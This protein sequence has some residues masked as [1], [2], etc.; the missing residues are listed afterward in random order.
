MNTNS[1]AQVENL[2]G[3]GPSEAL[4][5]ANQSPDAQSE[6]AP[7][8]LRPAA[9]FWCAVAFAGNIVLFLR[10]L[11]M[12]LDGEYQGWASA[13]C[14]TMARAF[15][16]LGALHMRFVPI[17][18]N[19]PVGSDPDVYLHWPPLYPLVLAGFL[20]IFGDRPAS[21]RI[22]EL[23]V[24]FLT[25]AIVMLIARRLFSP[26]VAL[27]S[28]FFYLACRA[29]F[30]GGSAILQQPLAMLF[31][32]ASVLFF[33]L[34]LKPATNTVP[35][36]PEEQ[37]TP[38]HM[39]FALLGVF[40]V[41]LTILTAWDP[42]FIPFGLFAGAVYLRHRAG[43]R[44]GS[45]Y[46]A[47]AVITFAGIQA[48]YILSYPV[49]FKNQLATIAYRV[50]MHFNADSSVR[51]HTIVD[52]THF[53]SQLSL[54]GALASIST[55]IYT[56]IGPFAI[57]ACCVVF[58]IWIQNARLRERHPDRS[59]VQLFFGLGLP[60]IVWYLLMKNYVAIHSF[61]LIMATPFAGIACAMVLDAIWRFLSAHPRG[62]GGL[63]VMA[64]VFPA[65]ILFPLM[66]G[67]QSAKV[68]AETPQ[69]I[70]FS[71][72]VERSTPPDAVVLSPSESM[73]PIYYSHR[74][75]VRGIQS[76]QWLQ[77]SI[78]QAHTA[79]PGSP[80][81]LALLDADRKYFPVT[82]PHLKLLA[83]Q[84]DAAVYE[85]SGGGAH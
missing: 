59:T 68:P 47:A 76:D 38:L 78:A 8:I 32:S 4:L 52:R 80:L 77:V 54:F 30:Q 42:V 26:R 58:A 28:G 24:V 5:A 6:C 11:H 71:P 53:S 13:S 41:I 18:N 9:L 65:L 22:L 40:F 27:L 74:H 81:F 62:R 23:L 49:L 16:A 55:F 64:T 84:G 63:W 2:Q 35:R 79:F 20:R 67:I 73:V 34:A 1:E 17:Q 12:S 7:R 51:L 75:I 72:L 57:L 3:T 25:A 37:E 10:S 70:D 21:G 83:Q 33:L 61:V 31:A 29:T 60:W 69:F 82:L 48:D 15:N 39:P 36:C 50:G 14:L 45:A 66:N 43:M 56:F 46:I 85:L 19:L 44:L